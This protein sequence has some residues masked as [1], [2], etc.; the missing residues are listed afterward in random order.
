MSVM[1]APAKPVE[2]VAQLRDLVGNGMSVEGASQEVGVDLAIAQ[3]WLRLPDDLWPEEIPAAPV[4]V[5]PAAAPVQPNGC[6]RRVV[7]CRIPTPAYDRLR[8]G[9][10]PILQTAAAALC[11]GLA[12]PL[13]EQARGRFLLSRRLLAVPVSREDYTKLFRLACD[14][15]AGDYREAGGWTIARGVGLALLLPCEADL[16]P[17]PVSV[18]VSV[19]PSPAPPP[20]RFVL[21]R[22]GAS[23][24]PAPPDDALVPK[25]DELRARREALGLSQRY[26][27]AAAGL[28][29]GLICE[30]ERGRRRHVLTRLKLSETLANLERER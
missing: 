10:D 4:V 7:I 20:T 14:H 23:T 1:T 12:L 18:V 5:V 25:G 13:P 30:I 29:R 28:S 27:A 16:L 11:A 19:P 15:F 3:L 8:S 6:L 22:R 17:R 9:D 26:L 24:P 21:P 2:R